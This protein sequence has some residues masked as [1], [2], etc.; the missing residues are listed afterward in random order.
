MKEWMVCA[1]RINYW[2]AHKPLRFVLSYVLSVTQQYKQITAWK[3]SLQSI[4]PLRKIRRIH[5]WHVCPISR[6]AAYNTSIL[7]MSNSF[8]NIVSKAQYEKCLYTIFIYRT[9]AITC[10]PQI[11]T[12]TGLWKKNGSTKG[13]K[14]S[15]MMQTLELLQL[16]K[17]HISIRMK[18]C[19]TVRK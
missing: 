11:V 3:A 5:S 7:A 8:H 17:R 14:G 19:Q 13:Y 9:K 15:T 18:W 1:S 16:V 10:L 2:N 6:Y 4:Q 12:H